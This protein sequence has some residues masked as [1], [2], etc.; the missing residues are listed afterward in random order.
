MSVEKAIKGEIYWMQR[1]HEDE[2]SPYFC[3]RG[4]E[5]PRMA[6]IYDA[7]TFSTL[8][9]EERYANKGYTGLCR[10]SEE[11]AGHL[12]ETKEQAEAPRGPKVIKL[13]GNHWSKGKET[14]T[15]ELVMRVA[16]D[17]CE[18]KTLPFDIP[19]VGKAI[20][21]L[22]AEE[23]AQWWGSAHSVYEWALNLRDEIA[24]CRNYMASQGREL[25]DE[26]VDTQSDYLGC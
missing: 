21:M 22:E 11:Y 3:I 10:T 23:P 8:S 16:Q 24:E 9:Q 15:E 5:F 14:V 19:T 2:A 7:A 13:P 17:F 25:H 4:G 20:Q 26:P 1:G 6:R 12:Y 18:H